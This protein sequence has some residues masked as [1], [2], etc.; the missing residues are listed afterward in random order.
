MKSVNDIEKGDYIKTQLYE[1]AIFVEFD[2]TDYGKSAIF[3]YQAVRPNE[4]GPIWVLSSSDIND[5]SF[6]K[7]K[8]PISI[9]VANLKGFYG[10]GYEYPPLPPKNESIVIQK[11]YKATYEEVMDAETE[12][13]FYL[14][15][16]M[17]KFSDYFCSTGF[18]EMVRQEWNAWYENYYDMKYA[19]L[20]WTREEVDQ[21]RER[22]MNKT[23]IF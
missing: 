23:F 20:G 21:E 8:D 5:I 4:D 16:I 10:E 9:Y 12:C 2:E 19:E 13:Y 18:L 17:P 1:D 7:K 3:R 15:S 11:R 6:S 22:M 14:Q